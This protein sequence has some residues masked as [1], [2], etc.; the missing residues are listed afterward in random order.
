[1][2]STR[3]HKWRL[4]QAI[5]HRINRNHRRK[6]SVVLWAPHTKTAAHGAVGAPHLKNRHTRTE[7]CVCWG[8]A[9][10]NVRYKFVTDR[11]TSET[12]T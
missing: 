2:M 3:E 9:V 5:A 10:V 1:M 7:T 4:T 12:A 8:M 11:F 6:A